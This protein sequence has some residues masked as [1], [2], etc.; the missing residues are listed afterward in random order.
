MESAI[1]TSS[2]KK[3]RLALQIGVTG[4]CLCRLPVDSDNLKARVAE[5]LQ[6]IAEAYREFASTVEAQTAYDTE[7][8]A[9]RLLSPLA[10]GADRIAAMAGLAAGFELQCP[11]PFLRDVYA[12]DFA[13]VYDW[14]S[15]METLKAIMALGY[16]ANQHSTPPRL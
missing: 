2:P 8:P 6:T 13:K 7:S 10:E 16:R 1:P 15:A 9:L 5:T 14:Q 11:L 3:N 12:E 4:H